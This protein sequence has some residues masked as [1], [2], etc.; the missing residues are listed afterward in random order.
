M[1]SF[2]I[3]GIIIKRR[4][5]GESDRMLTVLTKRHG[6]IQIKASGVR[7]IISRRSPHIELLNYSLLTLHKGKILSTLIE[8]QTVEN[9]AGIKEDLTKIGFAYHLCELIDGLCAENQEL[10]AVFDLFKKTLGQLSKEIEIAPIIH[11]FEIQLLTTL[12]FYPAHNANL[13]T[14]AYIE[15]ILERRLKTRPLLSHFR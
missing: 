2:K 10:D 12:G 13:D 8:A 14:T 5:L 11:D 3:E 15:D 9:H 6:K 4:N 7:K 1:R